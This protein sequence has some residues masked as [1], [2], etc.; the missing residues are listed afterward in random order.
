LQQAPAEQ[1][2]PE[3]GWADAEGWQQPLPQVQPHSVQVQA[4]AEQPLSHWPQSQQLPL[5]YFQAP[6]VAGTT[7]RAPMS[8]RAFIAMILW[9]G[10]RTERP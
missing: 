9:N 2:P 6:H 4:P 8:N 5:A 1:E 3:V 7:A 10:N